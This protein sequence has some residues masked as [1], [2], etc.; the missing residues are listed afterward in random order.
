VTP[1][2]LERIRSWLS[3]TDFE[4]EGSE[5]RKHL[6]AHV[7]GTGDWLFETEQY[8]T[9]HGTEGR[10]GALWIQ[11][12]PGSGKSVVAANLVQTLKNE[13]A[14]VLF[15][16]S[17]RIIK[18][19]SE[20]RFLVRDCLYQ[21][22]DHSTALQRRLKG[23]TEQHHDVGNVPFHELWRVLLFGLS[24]VPKAYLVFDA[25][26]ELGTE[27][28]DYLQC[29]LD[30][31][32]KNPDSIKLIMTSRPIPDLQAVL[33]GSFLANVRLSGNSVER[34]IGTYITHRL[35]SQKDR[36]LKAEDQSAIKEVLCQKGQGLFL[37]ARLML[38]E[39][40]Q[41][42]APVSVQL[43]L[44]Q[45]PSSL[46]DMY[47]DLLNDHSARSGASLHFQSLLLSW[48]IHASRPL[49]VT[50]LAA[51]I[52]SH[53]NR[54]GLTDSQ[55]GKLMVR[56]SCGS[57][58]EILDDETVQVIHHSFTEFLLDKSRSSAR[59]APESENWFPAF[60]PARVHRS[61]TISCVNYLKSGCFNSWSIE[62]RTKLRYEESVPVE[63]QRDLM[64]QFHFLQYASQNLLYHAAQYDAFDI[65]LHRKLNELLQYGNHDFESWKDF[66]F[67]KE[68]KYT[69]DAF[70]PLHVAAQAGLTSYVMELL[71]RGTK[72]PD[73]DLIDSQKRTAI[74][75][76]AMYGHAETLAALLEQKASITINDQDGLQPIHH[77]AKG[78]HVNALHCL[79]DAGADP[80]CP[81]SDEDYSWN[82]HISSTIGITPIQVACE[83]GNADA[84]AALLERLTPSSRSSILPHWASKAGQAKVLSVLFQ[85]PEVLANINEKDNWGNTALYWAALFGDSATARILLE[86]GADVHSRSDD[87]DPLRDDHTSEKENE[88]WRTPLHGWANS[89]RRG[90]RSNVNHG[91]ID[92]WGKTA[93]FLIEYGCDI[94][95]RDTEGQTVMFSWTEQM[96]Y[97]RGDSDRTARFVS[98]LLKY[99]ANPRATDDEG[100]TPLHLNR[101]YQDSN[102]VGLF[103]KAGADINAIRPEDLATPLIVSAKAQ[104]TDAKPY[105]ENG[106][107]FN[108]QDVDGNTALHHICGS[109]LFELK[110]VEEWLTVADPT[111]KNNKGET[112]LYNLRFGNG[113]K[114]RLE[115]I[116]LLMK[117]GL[118]LESVDRFRRTALLSF[119]QKAEPNFIIEL[120]KQ[121]ANAK[122]K[123]FQNKSC[124]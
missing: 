14:P 110:D 57:L 116:P 70:Q 124:K 69:P 9:W 7:T 36:S 81:K 30:L 60:T 58:L 67:A 87:V 123:D 117:K 89:M 102:I 97:G 64:L 56:T 28:D 121:G 71:V 119:C 55:D 112:C 107:D 99:G 10:I 101:R 95:A 47:V 22:L 50:E 23:L 122:A 104:R 8:K 41:K 118:D 73:P 45:L 43:Q 91:S 65:G 100:N 75:Y 18:S 3:P 111:I 24:T 83:M 92:E 46:E 85:Y 27:Q 80:M 86:N 68:G 17:R 62:D 15:F 44:E 53:K 6:N 105:I 12:I 5:Y 76:A 66:L 52:N 114:G 59:E 25:L 115:A 72:R 79:L 90:N 33:R 37:Y 108:I 120:V 2:D 106:A 40:L 29:L 31:G 77:A 38:D 94:E 48:V 39:L 78:N 113:G 61:M 34:D 49:R 63:Q 42:Y 93:T 51:L 109:W 21:F 26:D 16:F 84:V 19:N 20:P 82:K 13:D 103:T 4:S 35:V 74:S 32:R 98:F 54:G 1:K 88:P 11:G 96:G